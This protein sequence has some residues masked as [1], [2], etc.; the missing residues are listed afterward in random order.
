MNIAI[1]GGGK[2]GI[3]VCEALVGGDYSITIVD[4]NDALLDRLSQQFDV[5]TVNEDA[6]DINVLKEIGINKFQ[7][8]LVATGRDETNLVIGGFAKKLGCHR[9][10]V[11]VR[12]PEY[13]KHFEFIRTSMGIDYIVNPDFAITMEIYKY[14][15][16]KYTLNNGVFTSGRIALIEFKAKRKKELIGLKMPEVRR[17]MPDMLIAA[18]SRNGKVIIPHGNDEIREDDA[19]Y[20]V[21]EKNEIMELNKKVH[22]KGKYTDL[23]KVMIIGGGK[24]GYY[25]AQRL[26]D[27][28]ASVKLVEQSKERCQYLSTRIPNVMILHGD[29]TD[30]DMLEEEN[31]DEMDA[32]VTATGYDEQNLLLAL[33]AKQKGIEDVISKISRESYS[34]LIEEMG[35]DMVLNPL[36]ITAAYI[37]SIIQGEKR[38]ISSMLV[39]GQAEIIEVVATPGMKMVGDTLQNLNL[40]K[41]VLIASIYRQGEVIIPDGNARIKDGDRVI[42]FSLLSDIADLEKL[43][44][45]R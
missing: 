15:S 6:R 20:V 42:M 3:K 27:F 17:L 39:Q 36:D 25:L 33:T 38:V 22:V 19:V 44:K 14:L 31:I 21:G 7:Y 24:T 12:D 26:A 34:G 1:I 8:V 45:I 18:I 2:L 32:F 9:V 23:Q 41:G 13:M 40:P 11:R 29:G 16:E 30:M 43:M 28:G 37:F 4:T 35:V 5:M 10:I